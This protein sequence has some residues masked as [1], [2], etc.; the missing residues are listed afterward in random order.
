[1]VNV[2][3]K[4]LAV[5]RGLS[6]SPERSVQ[7]GGSTLGELM[8]DLFRAENE[9]LKSRLF[10]DGRARPDVLMF[11]NGVEVSLLGGTHAK[12]KDGDEVTFLPSVH[13]G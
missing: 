1:M 9:Q 4:Y 10:G 12:L 7:M 8:A 6:D 3:V 13:G 5:L 2:K 11:I